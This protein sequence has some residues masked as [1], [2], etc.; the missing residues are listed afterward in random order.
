MK[1]CSHTHLR[2][3]PLLMF[4]GNDHIEF[5]HLFSLS[6]TGRTHGFHIPEIHK[7]WCCGSYE[8]WLITV[9]GSTGEIELFNPFSKNRIR[10]PQFHIQYSII[11]FDFQFCPLIPESGIPGD[12]FQYCLLNY[13][14][15]IPDDGFQFFPLNCE[16]AI[17]GDGFR[18]CPLNCESGI[19]GDHYIIKAVLSG[20][21]CRTSDF[22]VM[23]II[24][25]TRLLAY[26]RP[27]AYAWITI[28]TDLFGFDDLI[29]YKGLFYAVTR[30]GTVMTYDF[31][32][33]PPIMKEIGQEESKC[34]KYF[35]VES[36][37]ELLLVLRYLIQLEIG[38]K[39]VKFEVRKLDENSRQWVEM[40][41]IGDRILFLGDF[42]SMSISAK[43]FPE[44]KGNSIYFNSD[45]WNLIYKSAT[46]LDIG[47]FNFYNGS[48]K[49]LRESPPIWTNPTFWIAPCPFY[50]CLRAVMASNVDWSGLQPEL[51]ELILDQLTPLFDH[52]RLTRLSNHLHFACVCSSWRLVAIN[53]RCW[54]VTVDGSTGE[55]QLFNPFS[56][57]C[58][59]LPSLSTF[60]YPQYSFKPEH[61]HDSHYILKAVLSASSCRTTD[62]V[63]VA[64][65]T[66]M[67]KL[68]YYK[69]GAYKWTT[70]ETQRSWFVDVIYYRGLFYA[71]GNNGPI[72]T[73]DFSSEPPIVTEI[74]VQLLKG[75]IT[76]SMH[77][78]VELLGGLLLVLR[79]FMWL[80]DDNEDNNDDNQ[81]LVYRGI[82]RLQYK[83]FNFQVLKLDESKRQWIQMESIG[84]HILFLGNSCSMSLPAQD[85]PECKGNSIYFN[86]DYWNESNEPPYSYPN[87]GVFN[88][89]NGSV[90]P[91]CEP[92]P[93]W[94]TPTFW[95][96]PDP[97]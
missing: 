47:V 46:D 87:I 95:I 17:P 16:S 41:N 92:P 42:C 10:F 69:P 43:D 37:G 30:H 94:T 3:L 61:L 76:C 38:Y 88:F 66:N 20:N 28:E 51:V 89:E 60:S 33:E 72:V 1:N 2:Q 53:N 58:I 5:R 14:S 11:S 97:W 4:P 34:A 29:Y 55:I 45:R 26:Y 24:S 64:I 25:R 83:T 18:F 48:V 8:G 78:L 82:G 21:S 6:R 91:F 65:V 86:D 68:A 15:E 59:Q 74:I 96:T 71:I 36:S 93:M 62:F 54:L 70:I 50:P 27:G 31:S 52:D 7:K 57:F 32:S 84:N 35:L 23:G 73:Y 12:D 77:Y 22:L 13:E 56:R 9:N 67:R 90:E 40:E 19:P 75:R 49:R 63:V 81:I 80:D 44:C 85:F 39:T 79:H